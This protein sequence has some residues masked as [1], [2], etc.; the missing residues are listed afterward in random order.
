MNPSRVEISKKLVLVN[1]ASSVLKSV[2]GLGIVIWLQGHLYHRVSPDEYKVLATTMA[3]MLFVPLLTTAVAGGITR[4]TTEAYSLGQNR[5]VTQITSTMWPLCCGGALLILLV[6]AVLT[7]QIGALLKLEPRYVN[8]A[9]AMFAVLLATAAWRISLLPFMTGLTI[10]QK[11]LF[12]NALGLTTQLL[13]LGMIVI[14]FH[15]WDT[16]V[17]WVVLATIPGTILELT[18]SF[19]YSRRL[20]PELRFRRS[21]FRREL[22]RPVTSLG[23]WNLLAR[24]AGVIRQMSGPL[25]LA[26]LP[27]ERGAL[28]VRAH[29]FGSYVETRFLPAVLGPLITLQPGMIGMH[30]SGQEQRLRRTYFRTT[31]Y[32][33]WVVALF[34][35]PAVIFRNELYRAW[36]GPGSITE[37]PEAPIVMMLLFAKL[38]FNFPQPVLAQIA[39][40]QG[41]SRLTA[42]RSAIIE[43]LTLIATLYL[44]FG[45]GMGAVGVAAATLVGTAVLQPALMW[46]LGLRLTN[47]TFGAWTRSV[48]VPGAIPSL[49]AGPVWL[50]AGHWLAPTSL[51]ELA[52]S[53]AIGAAVYALVLV[54]FCLSPEDR[55]DL[56]T[57]VARLR[58]KRGA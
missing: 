44:V 31:R 47:A 1:S 10:K 58:G 15:F 24:A 57:A 34:G 26:Q 4:F 9:R 49:V 20:V 46:P 30:A 45:E 7:W 36:L 2:L 8:D 55:A 43:G 25:L 35:I 19:V 16:R 52:I 56:A 5:R 13:H 50:A 39:L 12:R 14:A 28:Q 21:E 53:G 54:R 33:L 29:R 11:F 40:A 6:G 22:I 18:W 17:I 42:I 32:L 41:K 27:G 37:M 23:G 3:L 48:L 38:P 51:V